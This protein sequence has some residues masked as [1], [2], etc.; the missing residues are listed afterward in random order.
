MLPCLLLLPV[1][2]L[3]GFAFICAEHIV[4][5]G[6]TSTVQN[7]LLLAI[8]LIHV[9]ELI[10]AIK[11]AKRGLKSLIAGGAIMSLTTLTW[12]TLITVQSVQIGAKALAATNIQCGM[13]SLIIPMFFCAS[14]L[15]H[16]V[17]YTIIAMISRSH[18][19][20]HQ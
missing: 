15:L 1:M 14:A 5:C 4:H 9:I 19:A 12:C 10:F 6:W 17:T 8:V 7:G 20:Q 11:L 3:N 16:F 13:G 18:H 2:V